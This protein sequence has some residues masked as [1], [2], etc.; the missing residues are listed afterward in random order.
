VTIETEP[1][2]AAIAKQVIEFAGLSERVTVVTGAVAD[3][4]STFK[5]DFKT[6]HVDMIFFLWIIGKSVI[7]RI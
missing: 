7:C 4:I 1:K 2:Y 3:V 5:Q 6:D